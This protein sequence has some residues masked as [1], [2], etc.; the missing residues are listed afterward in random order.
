[1]KL[2]K[3][4][5]TT[6]QKGLRNRNRSGIGSYARKGKGRYAEHYDRPALDPN[7]RGICSDLSLLNV[8]AERPRDGRRVEFPLPAMG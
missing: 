1:V 5:R 4:Y 2:D 3:P 8:P 6:R 7:Y